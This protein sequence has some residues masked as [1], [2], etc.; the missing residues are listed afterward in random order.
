MFLCPS[1]IIPLIAVQNVINRSI[2]RPPGYIDASSKKRVQP[3]HLNLTYAARLQPFP[4][5]TRGYLYYYSSPQLPPT[6]AEVRFRLA[7]RTDLPAASTEW[8]DLLLPTGLPWSIPLWKIA[9]SKQYSFLRRL[10]R[11]EELVADDLMK[12][13][14]LEYASLRKVRRTQPDRIL[15]SFGQVM[16]LRLDANYANIWVRQGKEMV[17]FLVPVFLNHARENWER[18]YGP[19]PSDRMSCVTVCHSL[20]NQAPASS[21]PVAHFILGYDSGLDKLYSHVVAIH[22]PKSRNTHRVSV[23][24]SNLRDYVSLRPVEGRT[25]SSS[26]QNMIRIA[27]RGQP[28]LKVH[29]R[30]SFNQPLNL[31]QEMISLPS[32]RVST[33]AL[34]KLSQA[35]MIDLSAQYRTDV[36][37]ADFNKGAASLVPGSYKPTPIK[38]VSHSSRTVYVQFPA[39]TTGFLY[40]KQ[41]PRGVSSMAG[42]VRFKVI[43]PWSSDDH[44]NSLDLSQ[45]YDLLTPNGLPW[46]IPLWMITSQPFYSPFLHLLLHDGLITQGLVDQCRQ[47]FPAEW[48]KR[49]ADS[50]V[51]WSIGRK[52]TATG[53]Q[54]LSIR[55][56]TPFTVPIGRKSKVVWLATHAQGGSKVESIQI[57]TRFLDQIPIDDSL[58]KVSSFPTLYIDLKRLIDP[59]ERSVVLSIEFSNSEVE[60]ERPEQF[61]VRI[62]QLPGQCRGLK[63]LDEGD[64]LPLRLLVDREAGFSHLRTMLSVAG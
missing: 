30:H 20:S 42:E 54:L 53:S 21:I 58:S 23:P 17:P 16:A 26:F 55:T 8:E 41:P 39:R 25:I 64:V 37:V 24:S 6:A 44:S 47:V 18:T 33:L 40:Y 48:T 15:H 9:F 50:P 3:S 5:N 35:D 19:L 63:G 43:P 59:L 60:E 29:I 56:G 45:G 7:D 4:S 12:Q 31:L 2:L 46:S 36:H 1:P 57:L 34:E 32:H 22:D 27:S 28:N 49:R 52:D 38:Y 11:R 10:L 62:L 61:N 13:C 51:I 14:E